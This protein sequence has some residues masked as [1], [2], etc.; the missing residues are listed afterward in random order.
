MGENENSNSVRQTTPI[1]L[2]MGTQSRQKIS[3]L[4]RGQGPLMTEVNE[5]IDEVSDQLD[6][7]NPNLVYMPVIIV[8]KS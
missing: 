1:I 7:D 3:Q 2:D 6:K 8:Y 4:K 5:I